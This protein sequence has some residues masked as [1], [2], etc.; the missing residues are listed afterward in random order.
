[1]LKF[2]IFHFRAAAS[3]ANGKL[4]LRVFWRFMFPCRRHIIFR[5]V[6][7]ALNYTN[8]NTRFLNKTTLSLK[9]ILMNSRTSK[10]HLKFHQKTT[11]KEIVK[12]IVMENRG[13]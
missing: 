5:N 4:S 10:N 1:M 9:Q 7:K 13:Q 3:W 8:K 6:I 12:S 11:E 2:F